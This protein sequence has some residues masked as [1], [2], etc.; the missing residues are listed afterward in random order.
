MEKL[1]SR[2]ELEDIFQRML[3]AMLPKMP[4]QDIRPTYQQ[5]MKNGKYVTNEFNETEIIPFTPYD[6]VI[7]ITVTTNPNS[8]QSYTLPNGIT[9]LRQEV[10]LQISFYGGNSA[11]NSTCAFS[12]MRVESFRYMLEA[13]GLYLQ[14]MDETV[15]Q[16][17]ELVNE[18]YMERHDFSAT[19]NQS[20]EIANPIPNKLAKYAVIGIQG[21]QPDG[22]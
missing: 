15:A 11:E 10:S 16:F 21:E 19:F 5:G 14:N 9:Q 8:T 18:E 12:L 1:K 2:I 17:W 6:N 20:I 22:I 4:P 3:C 13:Q 7:Y